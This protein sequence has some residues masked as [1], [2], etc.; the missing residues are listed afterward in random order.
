[1]EKIILAEIEID[2]ASP[3]PVYEQIK[4]GIKHAIAK[5]ILAGNDPLPSIRELAAFHKINPNTVAR[6]YRDLQ[7]EKIVGG[8]AGKG[9]WVEQKESTAEEEVKKME[10]LKEDFLKL[11]EKGIEMGLSP[12][13]IK[14]MILGFFEEVGGS[15]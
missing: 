5:K 4:K 3:V 8:R 14:K 15:Q 12:E 11:L 2:F 1:M 10:L 13:S 7:Q 9:F 6:A